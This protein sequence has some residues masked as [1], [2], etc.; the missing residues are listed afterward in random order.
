MVAVSDSGN[1]PGGGQQADTIGDNMTSETHLERVLNALHDDVEDI[2]LSSSRTQTQPAISDLPE[3]IGRFA[4]LRSLNLANNDLTSLPE[5]IGRLENLRI[6]NLSHNRLSALPEFIGNLAFLEV[7]DL[8]S[9]ALTMW[10]DPI[11]LLANLRALFLDHN[12]IQI[13]PSRSSGCPIYI[14]FCSG[15]IC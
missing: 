10:P 2:D 5:A 7:L 1:I 11:S 4:K 15:T 12:R 14:P 3:G 8:R 9:N 6:L 13:Y